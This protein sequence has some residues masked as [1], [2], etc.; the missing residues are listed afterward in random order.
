[1]YNRWREHSESIMLIIIRDKIKMGGIMGTIH[2]CVS[3]ILSFVTVAQFNLSGR[4]ILWNVLV[5]NLPVL[6]DFLHTFNCVP[7]EKVG[8]P[9]KYMLI[10][11]VV[12]LLISILSSVIVIGILLTVDN[13]SVQSIFSNFF[14]IG[15]YFLRISILLNPIGVLADYMCSILIEEH[16][17]ETKV[18]VHTN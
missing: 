10:F 6:L 11:T 15:K 1:M 4:V 3:I 18:E 14:S 16:R 8:K 13:S 7:A 9:F 12:G 2:I 5:F 17:I